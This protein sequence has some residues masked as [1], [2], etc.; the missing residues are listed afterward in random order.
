MTLIPDT[1]GL[2]AAGHPAAAAAAVTGAAA[3]KVTV[4]PARRC[5][6]GRTAAYSG[7]VEETRPPLLGAGRHGVRE[8]VRHGDHRGA[9]ADARW[10]AALRRRRPKTAC[11]RFW[12]PR[13]CA[14]SHAGLRGV[15]RLT[16][17][18]TSLALL[19]AVGGQGRPLGAGY[20]DQPRAAAVRR[21]PPAAGGGRCAARCFTLRRCWCGWGRCACP[22]RAAAGWGP[23]R[24]ISIW[25][26]WP[27]MGAQIEFAADAVGIAPGPG[28]CT[29]RTLRC[30]CPAWAPPRTLLMAAACAQGTTVLRGGRLRAGGGGPG[31]LFERLRGAHH[32]G[33]H[34]GGGHPRPGRWAGRLHLYPGAR[35]H[36]RRHLRR[37]GGVR[38]G[39]T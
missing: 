16:D 15:P 35:P 11:C 6:N 5:R 21:Y 38:R 14:A 23:A 20:P 34:A 29:A 37:R 36:R 22:C 18:D 10:R 30:G 4:C 27:A 2:R 32:R 19:G 24:W 12:R 39:R 28:G 7:N 31:R 33:G 8:A 17:V 13:C 9:G 1:L 26:A 3:Q 25:T